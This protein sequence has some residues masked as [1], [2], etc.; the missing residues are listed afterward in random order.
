MEQQQCYN[1][2]SVSPEGEA[3]RRSSRWANTQDKLASI[4]G[5]FLRDN[6][7]SDQ[8]IEEFHERKG[9]TWL[10]QRPRTS[11][12]NLNIGENFKQK[13]GIQARFEVIGGDQEKYHIVFAS[14]DQVWHMS[15][16]KLFF[17]IY[18]FSMIIILG[19]SIMFYP[20]FIFQSL[21]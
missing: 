20:D 6:I 21:Y 13:F 4:A 5:K 3:R 1:L 16:G 18:I 10:V 17:Q 12:A 8:R 15:Y 11:K 9:T 14:P 19:G 7:P 2:G